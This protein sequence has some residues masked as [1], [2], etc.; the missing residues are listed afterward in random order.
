M[1]AALARSLACAPRRGQAPS[2][3]R[4][5]ATICMAMKK[6]VRRQRKASYVPLNENSPPGA[7]KYV[8]LEVMMANDPEL[9]KRYRAHEEFAR[10][11]MEAAKEEEMEEEAGVDQRPYLSEPVPAQVRV[12]PL[13]VLPVHTL[14]LAQSCV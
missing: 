14:R 11:L 7:E 5:Q 13:L 8:S 10:R 4:G 9:E 12:P 1:S 3:G 2:R 6:V